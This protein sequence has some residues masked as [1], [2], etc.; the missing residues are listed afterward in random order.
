M[1]SPLLEFEGV[2]RWSGADGGGFDL[3]AGPGD[4][5]VFAGVDPSQLHDL[6]DLALGLVVPRRGVVRFLG[7][8]WQ[9]L[10]PR[11]AE[12]RR[13]GIGRVLAAPGR[14]AWLEN[15]DVEENVQLARWF[16]PGVKM[17]MVRERS[18]R[19]AGT[20]G[21]EGGLPGT[22]PAVTPPEVLA[23]AQWVRAF[24]PDPLRLLVLEAP[25]S[26]VGDGA[27]ALLRAEIRRVREAGT[28]V[29]WIDPGSPDGLD[30]TARYDTVPAWLR[31]RG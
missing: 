23:R 8:D 16:E 10:D 13:R 4:C 28:A 6:G 21:L 15:L 14:A 27:G 26:G 22:R 24:L 18:R 31:R 11:E 30:E 7:D 17:E 2:S 3:A 12:R 9:R 29:W 5:V 1:A 20:F 25:E 19:L